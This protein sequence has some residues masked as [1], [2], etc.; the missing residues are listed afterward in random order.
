MDAERVALIMGAGDGTGAALVKR[1][2]K[3]GYIVVA[4]RRDEA[5]LASL[6]DEVGAS[7]GRAE[8]YAADA[9]REE[10]VKALVESVERETAPIQV[11]IYNVSAF[12][13]GQVTDLSS[14]D[15]RSSWEKSALGGFLMGR[16]VAKRMLTRDNG[17]I[18]F[19]SSTASQRG[20]ANYAALA[21]GR[22]ALRALAQSMARELG[23]K[24]LH[25]AH[26]IIDGGIDGPQLRER[27]PDRER[28]VGSDELIKP[29]DVAEVCWQLHQQPHSAW[30]QEI[31]IRPWTE[32]W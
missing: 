27:F 15:Y 19:N 10:E 6:V 21:G 18:L 17:T 23:P 5:K 28:Q 1:F 3:G 30:T 22:H 13:R 4:V 14:Q 8:G 2:A 24:G 29:E 32:K 20:M 12:M 31:V 26:I 16:E 11:A 9:T 25:I 7:G